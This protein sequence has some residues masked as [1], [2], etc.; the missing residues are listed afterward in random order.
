MNSSGEAKCLNDMGVSL[1]VKIE[2]SKFY[3]VLTFEKGL[4]KIDFEKFPI[5]SLVSIYILQIP[6]TYYSIEDPI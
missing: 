6:K 1:S 2:R 4:E 5:E 3:L